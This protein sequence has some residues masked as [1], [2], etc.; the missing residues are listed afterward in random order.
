MGD[1]KKRNWTAHCVLSMGNI[2][3]VYCG[4]MFVVLN[5]VISSASERFCLV[6]IG[7]LPRA[8]RSLRKI[9]KR[10][11]ARIAKRHGITLQR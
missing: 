2:S 5:S 6:E 1:S 8:R 11:R 10:P 9:L 7:V 4:R 3:S